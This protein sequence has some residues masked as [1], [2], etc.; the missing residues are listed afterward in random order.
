MLLAVVLVSAAPTVASALDA[1]DSF[2]K[3]TLIGSLQATGG[4]QANVEH[5]S[6]PSDNTFAGFGARLGYLPF[7]PFG[8]DWYRATVEPGIEGWFQYYLHPDHVAAG[9]AKAT[10]R[11]H[12]LGFGRFVPYLEI[13]AGAGGTGLDTPESRSTFTFV[14]E[15]GPGFSL[16]LSR[17]L[18]VYAGYRFQHFSNGNTSKPNRGYEGQSGVVGVSIFFR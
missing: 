14:L 18:A 9:G 16:M 7:Q 3:G 15:A 8:A 17:D 5:F 4:A 6:N 13:T 2:S 10:L 11:L 1:A 12:G